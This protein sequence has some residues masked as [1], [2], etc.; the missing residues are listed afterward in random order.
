M[1]AGN[2]P[3]STNPQNLAGDPDPLAAG[4]IVEFATWLRFD[5]ANHTQSKIV[6]RGGTCFFNGVRRWRRLG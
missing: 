1:E 6:L 3:R 5:V 2:T 4:T